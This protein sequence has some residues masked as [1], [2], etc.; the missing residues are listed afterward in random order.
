MQKDYLTRYISVYLAVIAVSLS[1]RGIH[2]ISH[3]FEQPER[4]DVQ[5]TTRIQFIDNFM[6]FWP[7]LAIVLLSGWLYI[8]SKSKPSL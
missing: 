5:A 6:L 4:R 7:F 2:L 1:L 3:D 8:A